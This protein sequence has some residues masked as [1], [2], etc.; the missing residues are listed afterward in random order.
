MEGIAEGGIYP[1]LSTIHCQ[2]SQFNPLLPLTL[3]KRLLI[4]Q[5]LS[6]LVTKEDLAEGRVYPPLS[7]IRSASLKIA[8]HVAEY[9][10]RNDL[11]FL[12]PEPKDK[13]AFIESHMYN[14]EYANY[15]PDV[16]EWPVST[17]I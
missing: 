11:A 9:A 8:A 6:G 4:V 2:T 3:L 16:F 7:T 15:I 17:R 13:K 1:P 12:L 5:C 10:Y 14:T